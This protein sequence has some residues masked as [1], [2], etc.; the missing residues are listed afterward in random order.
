MTEYKVPTD[1][2]LDA[3][4]ED[5]CVI[6]AFCEYI[7]YNNKIMYREDTKSYRFLIV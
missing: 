4:A 2:E 5:L 1:Y 6:E 7:A 3:L